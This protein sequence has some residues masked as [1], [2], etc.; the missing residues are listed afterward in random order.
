MNQKEK[1]D[2]ALPVYE[3]EFIPVERR[4]QDRRSQ[5]PAGPVPV[6]R[7]QLGRRKSDQPPGEDAAPN[8]DEGNPPASDKK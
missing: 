6:E 5:P 1:G 3:V 8:S 2:E 4:L 7:R